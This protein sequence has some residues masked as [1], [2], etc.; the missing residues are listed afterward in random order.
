MFDSLEL[1]MFQWA[2]FK[3]FIFIAHA[4]D[5]NCI[6]ALDMS[7]GVSGVECFNLLETRHKDQPLL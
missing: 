7:P 5:L 3:V 2:D 1:K 6:S 4:S